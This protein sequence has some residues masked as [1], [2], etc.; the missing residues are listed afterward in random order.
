MTEREYQ[1]WK[2]KRDADAVLNILRSEDGRRTL[3]QM[4]ALTHPKESLFGMTP[5][6]TAL[7]LGVHSVELAMIEFL[8][9]SELESYHKMELEALKENEHLL[10]IKRSQSAN[11]QQKGIL[12][13]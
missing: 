7:R 8:K 9:M 13:V 12:D 4:I 10:E 6:A 1:T 11:F 5:H 2:S 3:R